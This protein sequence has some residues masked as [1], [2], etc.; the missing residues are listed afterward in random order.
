MP[1]DATYV[2]I[3]GVWTGIL[4]VVAGIKR[5]TFGLF[6]LATEES[7]PEIERA[8]EL[9]ARAGLDLE[10]RLL[11]IRD[12]QF[13]KSRPLPLAASAIN[14]LSAYLDARAAAGAPSLRPSSASSVSRAV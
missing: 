9:A 13:F 2:R 8:F 14:V 12:T 1:S 7:D 4:G 5:T 6:H 3:R 11:E 10:G